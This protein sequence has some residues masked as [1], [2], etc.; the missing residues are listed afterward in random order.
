MLESFVLCLTKRIYFWYKYFYSKKICMEILSFLRSFRGKSLFL[1]A[2]GRGSALP[3]DFQKLLH[4]RAGI[5]DLPELPS[6][7]GPL[8][9]EG[10]VTESQRK[11]ARSFG[12]DRCWYGVNGATGLLQSAILAVA[13]PGSTILVPKNVHKSV[14]QACI[15]GDITPLLFDLPFSSDR[16]HY[17]PPNEALIIK[18][19]EV[20]LLKGHKVDA[21][22]LVN[23]SYQGYSSNIANLITQLH[24]KG[25]PV[26]VDEAHG[27]HFT[28]GAE[29]LPESALVAGADLVIHSLHKSATGIGQT[30][31]LW[32]QGSRVDPIA[33]KRCLDLFQTTSPSSLLLASCE[34]TLRELKSDEGK[35][36]FLSRVDSAKE[37]FS[38]LLNLELPFLGTDDPLRLLL[39]TSQVGIS[40][41][42]ADEFFIS[43][44]IFAELP[45]PGCLTF[46][47][48]FS[49]H[50]N[51]VK[52]MKRNWDK[53]LCAF[54]VRFP[55]RPFPKAPSE[56]LMSPIISCSSAVNS[57]NKEVDLLDA[58]GEI[59]VE[60]IC[61]YPPGIPI[62]I[63]GQLLNKSFVY[64]LIDQKRLYPNLI[65]NKLRVVS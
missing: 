57:I 12:V 20:L 30:A 9:S 8:E 65:P 4:S 16:G 52:D 50:N 47:L 34:S 42:D 62:V 24:L 18:V 35:K 63:P 32:S 36:K 54:P 55:L 60:L 40:G 43:Q 61:P 14:I 15:L 2:H 41:L 45:E 46:C 22:V 13:K 33:I 25:L 31:V 37:I 5:W 19:L 51:L 44:R 11:S 7:G 17:M 3:R 53:L 38:K 48:G 6:F 59:S 10:V 29:S 26:I 27:T 49:N 39:H 1:P 28:F 21:A 56:L 64:W 23:P 58:I